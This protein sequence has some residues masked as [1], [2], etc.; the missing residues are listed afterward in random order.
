M[1]RKSKKLGLKKSVI[2]KW[3]KLRKE[4]K[5]IYGNKGRPS[6]TISKEG[7]V[8]ITNLASSTIYKIKKD[9]KA[10]TVVADI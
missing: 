7:I 3:Y 8:I 2:C 9:L 5:L 1:W 4:G 6:S 10:N